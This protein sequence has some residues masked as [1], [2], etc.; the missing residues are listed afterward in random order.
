MIDTEVLASVVGIGVGVGVVAIVLYLFTSRDEPAGFRIFP[1][2]RREWLGYWIRTLE[3]TLVACVVSAFNRAVPN[4][5]GI[6][7]VTSFLLLL[8]T[9][10]VFW[11]R[12]C[13][14]IFSAVVFLILAALSV[15]LSP[16]GPGVSYR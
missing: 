16:A 2:D 5:V 4:T 12:D 11:R 3:L 1:A 6:A 8:A 10:V 15:L 7:L 14:F 9:T 13:D